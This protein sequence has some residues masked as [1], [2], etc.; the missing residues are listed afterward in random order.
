MGHYKISKLLDDS[1]VL[2]FVTKKMGWGNDLSSG[3]Y[4]FNKNIRFKTSMLR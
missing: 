1:T 4:Y 3:Q 2:K